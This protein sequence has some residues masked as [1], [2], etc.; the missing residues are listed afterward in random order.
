M[1]DHQNDVEV[2]YILQEQP[3]VQLVNGTD[4][5]YINTLDGVVGNAATIASDTRKIV[6]RSFPSLSITND[7]ASK[8]GKTEK[9]FLSTATSF[10]SAHVTGVVRERRPTYY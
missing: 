10:Y 7:L 9:D 2:K 4:K 8:H 3:T 1:T 5:T 6:W